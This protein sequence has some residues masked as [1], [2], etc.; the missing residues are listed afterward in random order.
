MCARTTNVVRAA[1]RAHPYDPRVPRSK[2]ASEQLVPLDIATP[3]I[4]ELLLDDEVM[5]A[6]EMTRRFGRPVSEADLA[7]ALNKPAQWVTKTIRVLE[8]RG[9]VARQR[10]TSRLPR[11]GWRVTND[12]I[13]LAF[14]RTSPQHRALADRMIAEWT[15][16]SRRL[17]DAPAQA[18]S[19]ELWEKRAFTLEHLDA[20][21]LQELR[22]I[23]GSLDTFMARVGAKYDG[24]PAGTPAMSNYCVALH[25]IPISEPLPP[26][27]RIQMVP[28]DRV[29][30]KAARGLDVGLK[31]LS[32]RERDIVRL[33]SAGR[34]RAQIA[35]EL[36]ITEATVRT[37]AS[38]CYR[39]LGISGRRELATR[40]LG[41]PNA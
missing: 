33:L 37:L 4:I 2:P 5:G 3:G 13:L 8:D 12:R 34:T 17:L 18:L 25:V 41:L 32:P 20:H 38:R 1:S 7:A 11:G 22:A 10:S 30:S 27:A 28:H 19:G 40:V 6:W 24:R 39:K 15:R 31:E 29:D 21:E 35:A 36:G 26:P 14:D 23:C 16:R 9:L